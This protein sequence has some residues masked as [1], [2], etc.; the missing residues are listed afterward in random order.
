MRISQNVFHYLGSL[1]VFGGQFSEIFP[2]LKSEAWHFFDVFLFNQLLIK[3]S[4]KNVSRA[5]SF[6]FLTLK[7]FWRA[8]LKKKILRQVH[9]I[10]LKFFFFTIFFNPL[11]STIVILFAFQSQCALMSYYL[12]HQTGIVWSNSGLEM[13]DSSPFLLLIIGLLEEVRT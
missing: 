8:S 2:E 7:Y 13:D 6:V 5:S 3:N 10:A 11:S 1:S 9:K 4:I 12:H